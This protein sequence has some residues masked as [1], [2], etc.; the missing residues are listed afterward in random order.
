MV[1]FNAPRPAVGDQSLARGARLPGLGT[2]AAAALVTAA[3][4]LPVVQSSSAT[5]TGAQTRQYETRKA[6]L[7]AAIYNAQTE[8]A[9][10]GSLER[11][12][13]EARGRLGMGPAEQSVVIPV[14]EPVPVTSQLPARYLP[15]ETE[16]EEP[17]ASS[18]PWDRL[19]A[20][21]LR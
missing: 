14:S 11:I 4:L 1:A 6:D 15:V 9:T 20:S 7:Q 3:A 12:D 10:L 21:L 8:I 5:T 16:R 2:I 17:K 19:L 18:R 13:R